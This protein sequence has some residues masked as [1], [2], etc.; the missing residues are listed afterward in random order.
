MTGFSAEWLRLREPA[1][2]RARNTEIA[3]AVAARFALR[4]SLSVVDLGCGTG[5]N[6]RATAPLLPLL[7]SWT[8][9]DRDEA[10]LDAA[11]NELCAWADRAS[12]DGPALQLHKGRATIDVTFLTCDLSRE[13]DRALA[14]HPQLV[15]ASALFDL[16]SAPFIRK[17]G[18]AIAAQHAA[19]YAVL[20]YNGV[21]RW[22]PHR[23]SDNQMS[24]AFHQHQLRDKGF[25]PAAGPMAP[26]LLADQ[27]RLEGYTVLEGDSP[28]RLSRGDRMLIEELAR[29][30][31]M[32]VADTGTV[33][34]K[35]IEAWIKCARTAADVG[36]TDTFGV[37]P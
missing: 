10:L 21:Q 13:L 1:D 19:L 22:S 9:V 11:R 6:L 35:V 7:Q 30:T 5:S 2:L 17:L 15:T 36:H 3:D 23:P 14:G 26:D 29:G 25:G 28:W 27:L 12:R 18:K 16:V 33:D 24:G 37:P 4:D 31:A 8:L 34:T 32:A 20:T